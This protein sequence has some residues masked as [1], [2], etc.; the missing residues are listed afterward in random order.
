MRYIIGCFIIFFLLGCKG[1]KGPAGPTGNA[2]VK[3]FQFTVTTTQ[4][5]VSVTGAIY[6]YQTSNLITQDI[7]DHGTVLVYFSISGGGWVSLPN[8][9]RNTSGDIF[10][11]DYAYGPGGVEVVMGSSTL[12]SSELKQTVTFKVIVMEGTASAAR[13]HSDN[14][15]AISKLLDGQ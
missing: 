3:S 5:S 2:N 7:A 6:F 8:S 1:E 14:Y 4:W 11:V 12:S 10:S 13:I 15:Q 9:F